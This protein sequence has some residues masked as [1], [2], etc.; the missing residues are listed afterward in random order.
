MLYLLDFD[1]ND[2]KLGNA[3]VTGGVTPGAPEE[4]PDKEPTNPTNPKDFFLLLFVKQ[5]DHATS[6]FFHLLLPPPLWHKP[7]RFF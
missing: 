5:C 3:P 6:I 4:Q 7:T 2:S 1:R